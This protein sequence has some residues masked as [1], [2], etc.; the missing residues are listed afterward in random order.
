MKTGSSP[1]ELE[2]AEVDG[3]WNSVDDIDLVVGTLNRV[4]SSNPFA[5]T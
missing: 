2:V 1:D 5:Y 4:Y 3:I